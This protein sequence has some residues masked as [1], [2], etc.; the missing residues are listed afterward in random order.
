MAGTILPE[1]C[2][3]KI[4]FYLASD[5]ADA[6]VVVGL[7]GLTAFPDLTG[8]D[9]EPLKLVQSV[10]ASVSADLLTIAD[11]W[12]FMSRAEIA[13]YKARQKAEASSCI[14]EEEL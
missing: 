10:A 3:A 11:D 5:K 1:G 13:D 9:P 7:G 8:H 6:E 2:E 14:D 12:R 4:E